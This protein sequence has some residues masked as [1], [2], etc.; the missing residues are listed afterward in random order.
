MVG[1]DVDYFRRLQGNWHRL[2][3]DSS[4]TYQQEQF[5]ATMASY[6]ISY[7]RAKQSKSHTIGETVIGPCAKMM[8][9]RM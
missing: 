7:I 8:A 2:R 5:N 6:K 9:T 1:K 3:L 4:G